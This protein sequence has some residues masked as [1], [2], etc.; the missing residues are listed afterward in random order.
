MRLRADGKH[1]VPHT[2]DERRV[3][4]VL[5]A[6]VV[7][8]AVS[9]YVIL[10]GQHS[11]FESN[12][13]MYQN[14]LFNIANGHFY[15]TENDLDIPVHV[16]GYHL[17]PAAFLTAPLAHIVALPVLLNLLQSVAVGSGVWPAYRLGR[18]ALGS[19]W[20]GLA[21]TLMYAL[22]TVIQIAALWAFTFRVM[23]LPVLMFA[24]YFLY[25]EDY[26]KCLVALIVFLLFGEAGAPIVFMI[27]LYL[28]FVKSQR[29]MGIALAIT[30]LL[31]MV[32]A[33]RIATYVNHG[34]YMY[35]FM[36]QT[37]LRL[38]THPVELVRFYFTLKNMAILLAMSLPFGF[39]YV[40][41]PTTFVLA[42]PILAMNFMSN[43]GK[44]LSASYGL[45]PIIPLL[46][47]ASVHGARNLLSI[48]GNA[49][50]AVIHVRRA[51]LAGLVAVLLLMLLVVFAV[52]RDAVDLG[53]FSHYFVYALVPLGLL[54][55]CDLAVLLSGPM[56][57]RVVRCVNDPGK[58]RGALGAYMLCWTVGSY[59]LFNPVTY[60]GPSRFQ[61]T[62]H[63]RLVKKYLDTIPQKA[64]VSASAE[65]RSYLAARQTSY[66]FWPEPG[67]RQ[68]GVQGR[69][70][71]ES[72][73]EKF[74][75]QPYKNPA[76]RDADYVVLDFNYPWMQRQMARDAAIQLLGNPDYGVIAYEEG[77]LML[78]ERAS[79]TLADFVK[80]PSLESARALAENPTD[81]P[82]EGKL[83]LLGYTIDRQK[84][85]GGK[86]FHITCFWKCLDDF[87]TDLAFV[88]TASHDGKTFEWEHR[89]LYG[90]A[91]GVSLKKGDIFKDE[92]FAKTAQVG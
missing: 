33:A 15:F 87:D 14:Y 10:W 13:Q 84:V 73:L 25:R 30:S 32:A 62:D 23:S 60:L 45:A 48:L 42:I 35:D 76:V 47:F 20:L 59:L 9:I 27:G 43:S 12:S 55:L 67:G 22:S 28:L 38:L 19:Y 29:G 6:F 46:L 81:I 79:G 90:L 63:D 71:D 50:V 34:V 82:L 51:L 72:M 56:I 69:L 40:L 77:F 5:W 89:P 54:A 1:S 4:W 16:L 39:L 61:I 7:A 68:I 58:L 26:R 2:G 17:V 31:Y 36:R 24:L 3:E 41:S 53:R 91:P 18:E 88:T 78:R 86:D 74:H 83:S 66:A 44:N 21:V 11:N 75:L 70:I 80:L 37:W 8:Y 52:S 65:L 64:S 85:N 92:Q 57:E 49:R